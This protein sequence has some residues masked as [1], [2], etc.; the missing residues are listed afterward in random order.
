MT[1]KTLADLHVH[2]TY[3]NDSL[4]TPKNLV[5]YAKKRGLNAVAVTD[6]NSLDGAYKIAKETDFL[7][8]PGM[9]VSSADGHIVALN[10][11]ELIPRGFSALE[12]VKLIHKA[13]GVAIACHP[14]VYFKGCLRENVCD[15]FDAIEVINARAF[16][17]KDSIAKAE[18]AAQRFGLSRVAGT[19]AHYGPQ[20]GYGYTEIIA[21]AP[22]VD[23]IME[24]IV[25]G[26]CSPHGCAVPY[27]LNAQQQ[28]L[29]IRRMLKKL[30]ARA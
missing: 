17:F 3:S 24:A 27:F 19:D 13:G 11:K 28:V 15:A 18:A 7:I 2:T 23:A 29:R 9:E 20:I 4:I 10:V 14:Y 8:I 5:F 22:T 16:P 6:H 25:A 30:A 12:T 26:K 21:E 1:I